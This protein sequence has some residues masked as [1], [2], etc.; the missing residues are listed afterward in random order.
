M[1]A[2]ET[3]NLQDE[4]RF[5][6]GVL[7]GFSSKHE[8]EGLLDSCHVFD[9]SVEPYSLGAYSYVPVGG[10]DAPDKLAE[11]IDDTLFSLA[12]SEPPDGDG[13]GCD[14]QWLSSR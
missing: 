10:L 6:G 3:T 8:L 9:W 2:R 13:T 12:H 14:C 1:E 5:L 11:P 4:V 7:V